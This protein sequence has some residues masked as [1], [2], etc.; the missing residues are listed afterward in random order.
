MHPIEFREKNYGFSLLELVFVV[1]VFAILASLAIPRFRCIVPLSR[2]TAAYYSMKQVMKECQ[3]RK[4]A[5]QNYQ[6][7]GDSLDGYQIQSGAPNDCKGDPSTG[8]I[9]ADP[10]NANEYPRFDLN[11]S[12][13]SFTCTF[14]GTTYQ[15]PKQCLEIICATIKPSPP[16]T[17]TLFSDNSGLACRTVD[18][19]SVSIGS[20][21]FY[22]DGK[23]DVNLEI[24]PVIFKAGGESWEVSGVQTKI[25]LN[26]SDTQWLDDFADALI[27]KI[28]NS[29]TLYSAE[30][31]ISTPGG[32]LI[33]TPSGALV[34]DISIFLGII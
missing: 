32:V 29:D 25:S 24:Q 34:D 18:S 33:Y 19:A 4:A 3:I 1:A 2:A 22:L 7:T 26:P 14:K 23:Y 6:F 17:S 8:L 30:K 5:G 10:S 15:N 20:G 21:Y 13:G 16:N 28:N 9:S 12:S 11:N 31:D 27:A